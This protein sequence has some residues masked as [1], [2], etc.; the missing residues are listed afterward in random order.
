MSDAVLFPHLHGLGP[1]VFDRICPR[2]S[3]QYVDCYAGWWESHSNLEFPLR[4]TLVTD[5]VCTQVSMDRLGVYNHT[6][7]VE[8]LLYTVMKGNCIFPFCHV[9]HQR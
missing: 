1:Q 7:S 6:L 8:S 3:L 5:A 2:Y 4:L 9:A